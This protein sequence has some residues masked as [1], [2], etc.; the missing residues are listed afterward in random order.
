MGVMQFRIHP[1]ELLHD[2]PQVHRAYMGS[3]DG[4]VYPT[5]L[6][7]IENMLVCR[8]P[9]AESCKLFVCWPVP[10]RGCPVLSTTCL[11][12]RDEPYLLPVELARGKI[13]Q[14][15]DQAG[16]WELAGMYIPDSY[17]PKC[18]AAQ[19]AFA[20]A[21][22]AQ[23]QPDDACHFALRAID[24]ACQASDILLA[25][26]INQR[27]AIRKKRSGR[28]PA[29]LGCTPGNQTRGDYA[30][31]KQF[32]DTF[33]TAFIP[34]QWKHIEAAE[35]EYN[36]DIFDD[37]IEHCQANNTL[38]YG[39]PLLDFS[40]EGLPEWLWQWQKDYFNLQSF[41]CDFVETAISRY[42]GKI[43]H[44]EICARANTGGTLALPEEARLS[45]T[46]KT[47][48]VARKVHD[49]I[50]LQIR[51][52]QPWGEYLARGQHRLS[53]LQFVDALLRTGIELSAINLEIAVGYHPGGTL[54]HEVID[55]SH[56]IDLWSSLGIPLIV[57]LAAPSTNGPDPQSVNDL[58]ID[59]SLWK[60]RWTEESQAAWIQHSLPL[61][62]AKQNVIGIF[63]SHFSD[64]DPHEFPHAGL[65]NTDHSPKT[66][67][68]HIRDYQL[69]FQDIH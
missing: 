63:W 65:L 51:I 35:G 59:N 60:E 10:G 46:A 11:R 5:R 32:L 28:L 12:E 54:V 40:T 62:M 17:T 42:I 22:A 4:R 20:H 19:S 26:Y 9:T 58:E 27:L 57:T 34:L 14:L 21:A 23:D 45:L 47:L 25:T 29:F 18:H 33:D 1:S 66:A 50:Q 52:S 67:L 68:Q 16:A 61:L 44:W 48:E 7:V 13:S 3:S 15:R 41:V 36:W 53:P 6:E 43:R 38:M 69:N 49:D 8:R 37:Q 39:G 2:W 31:Q 64:A 55:I 56:M 30:Q 24:L